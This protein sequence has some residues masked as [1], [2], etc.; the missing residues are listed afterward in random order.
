MQIP[1]DISA[2]H[3]KPEKLLYTYEEAAYALGM[4]RGALRDLVYKGRGP[5]TVSIGRRVFFAKDDLVAFI[6]KHRDGP[7]A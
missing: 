1:R 3:A 4:T 7:L 5:V 6:D 2:A